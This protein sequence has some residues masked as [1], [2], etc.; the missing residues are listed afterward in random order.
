M[1]TK[2][3]FFFETLLAISAL[4]RWSVF[5]WLVRSFHIK[6]FFQGKFF[7]FVL[8]IQC[9]AM[10]STLLHRRFVY[11]VVPFGTSKYLTKNHI[12]PASHIANVEHSNQ[13]MV[14][15]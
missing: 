9:N 12:I 4:E 8:K 1:I 2:N 11:A 7:I 3:V 15:I 14:E 13:T 6:M 5:N 10:V